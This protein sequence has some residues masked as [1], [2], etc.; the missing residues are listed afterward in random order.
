[1]RLI[2]VSMPFI[3]AANMC[4]QPAEAPPAPPA[5]EAAAPLTSPETNPV[6]KI[7]KEYEEALKRGAENHERALERAGVA[8]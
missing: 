3:L 8:E 1:M 6:K 4:G 5:P 2:L 7:P